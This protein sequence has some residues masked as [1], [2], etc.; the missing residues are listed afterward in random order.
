M[1]F[2]IVVHTAV[3]HYP[4]GKCWTEG[5]LTCAYHGW[6]YRLGDG[7]LMAALTEDVGR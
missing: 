3:C 6:T 2:L 5:T 7:E 1:R 4:E